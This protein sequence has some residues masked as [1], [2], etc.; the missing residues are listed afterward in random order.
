[1][2]S[3]L[4]RL[5]RFIVEHY[6]SDG[7]KTLCFELRVNY[8]DLPG[9]RI[10]AKAREL[11]LHL[12]QEKRFDELLETV[13]Q[14]RPDAY[15]PSGFNPDALY[16]ALPDFASD[17]HDQ[18]PSLALVEQSYL[19]A[20]AGEWA[21]LRTESGLVTPL[22]GVYVMLQAIRSERSKPEAGKADIA[23]LESR[24][25]HAGLSPADPTSGA[26]W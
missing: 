15:P 18:L 7:L 13:R 4:A 25:Q 8:D 10:S 1:M 26:V 19:Q 16:A 17:A 6:S 24:R 2:R 23:P 20:V 21:D 22:T 11:L 5:H 3:E 9:D 14:D 12:G